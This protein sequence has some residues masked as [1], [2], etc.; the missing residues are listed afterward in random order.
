MR[1]G[2]QNEDMET[3]WGHGNRMTTSKQNENRKTE[4]WMEI[5]WGQDKDRI[6][7]G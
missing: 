1:I 2:K 3:E 5:E 6:R 4:S 7:I